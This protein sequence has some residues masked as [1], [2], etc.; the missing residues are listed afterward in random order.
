MLHEIL[1]W[2]HHLL[3]LH[4]PGQCHAVDN[5]Y[6]SFIDSIS[7][8]GNGAVYG[9]WEHIASLLRYNV[10]VK[11]HALPAHFEAWILDSGIKMFFLNGG[12]RSY[13]AIRNSERKLMVS[14]CSVSA[15]A[16][17]NFYG[18]YM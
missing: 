11:F 17:G 16:I 5:Q 14:H 3:V 15:S 10:H 12:K 6:A 2:F 13:S 8:S 7:S 4:P 9:L 1:C 18:I